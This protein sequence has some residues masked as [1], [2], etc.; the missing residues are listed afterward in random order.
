MT[1]RQ[2]VE[3][4]ACNRVALF[5]GVPP[6]GATSYFNSTDQYALSRNC[7]QLQ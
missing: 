6:T 1:P 4:I 3:V 7:F 5:L 2:M